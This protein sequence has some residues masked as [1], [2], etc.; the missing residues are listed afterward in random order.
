MTKNTERALSEEEANALVIEFQGWAESIARCV[1]RAWNLD[2]KL[3]GLDGAALE[4]LLFCARRFD[5]ARGVPF[6]G[7]ARKRI[8]EAST[9]AARKCKG[10]RRSSS[11]NSADQRAKEVSAELYNVFPELHD[12]YLSLGEESHGSEDGDV[13]AALREMLVGASIIAAKQSMTD[14]LPDDLID[15]KRVVSMMAVLEP[16]HQLLMY[17]VYWDGLSLR[18]V[19]TEW[20]TDGLNVMREHKVLLAFLHKSMAAGKSATAPKVR[21]GLKS[22]AIKLKK[23]GSSGPFT[24]VLKSTQM[25]A[26]G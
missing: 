21:P 10:W 6:K 19:A 26:R 15:Y 8:H 18:T 24:D 20:E 2:W 4:A 1:A 13:R 14:P 5:P 23:D 22:M 9:D 17:K 25:Q 11:T 7:Y 16:V 12:G 3:D